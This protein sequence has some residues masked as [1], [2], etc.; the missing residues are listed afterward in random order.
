MVWHVIILDKTWTRGYFMQRQ[1][2]Q[3]T[4]QALTTQSTVDP[5]KTLGERLLSGAM[6]RYKDNNGIRDKDLI[7]LNKAITENVFLP[8]P[9]P[10]APRATAFAQDL[11]YLL[12]QQELFQLTCLM[13]ETEVDQREDQAFR[14]STVA[15][16]LVKAEAAL[17]AQVD[18][19]F[20][21]QPHPTMIHHLQSVDNS[22]AKDFN[23]IF[24]NPKDHSMHP[25][26]FYIFCMFNMLGTKPSESDIQANSQNFYQTYVVSASDVPQLSGGISADAVNWR[27]TILAKSKELEL[28]T[29]NSSQE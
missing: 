15:K 8:G 20:K 27:N 29:A 2:A 22:P 3:S 5:T 9:P 23:A 4:I 1:L 17:Y 13:C 6:T 21:Q 16:E 24:K 11:V 12:S 7:E 10:I 14:G 19:Q 26:D 25:R 18:D 28:S